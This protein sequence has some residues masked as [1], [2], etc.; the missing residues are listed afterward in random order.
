M[1]WPLC[2]RC[3]PSKKARQLYCVVAWEN[4][5]LWKG[6]VKPSRRRD[7]VVKVNMRREEHQD[8]GVKRQVEYGTELKKEVGFPPADSERAGTRRTVT[9]LVGRDI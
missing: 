1:L 8:T 4:T 6:L 9:H 3:V 7:G 5:P 2:R